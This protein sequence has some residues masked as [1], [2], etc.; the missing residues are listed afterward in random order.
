MASLVAAPGLLS[1]GMRT[2]S[3]SM[4]V[5]SSSLTRDQTGAPCIGSMESYPLGHQGSP[6]NFKLIN[7]SHKVDL[8]PIMTAFLP[9]APSSQDS[10]FSQEKR[11]EEGEVAALRLTARSQV[12]LCWLLK[13]HLIPR[14]ADALPSF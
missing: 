8:G 5:G 11:T 2:P 6:E 1:C 3:C 13:F 4:H 10:P 7:L 9:L 12:S 14:S